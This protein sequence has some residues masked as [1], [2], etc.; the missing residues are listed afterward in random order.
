MFSEE[1][2]TFTMSDKKTLQDKIVIIRSG[3]GNQPL[4]VYAFKVWV[5]ISVSIIEKKENV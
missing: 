2:F 3:F 5:N 4:E 1:D